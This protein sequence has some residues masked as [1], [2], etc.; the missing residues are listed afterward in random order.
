MPAATIFSMSVEVDRRRRLGLAQ[1]R[2][3]LAELVEREQHARCLD[4][5]RGLPIASSAVSPAM[6]RRAKLVG[7]GHAVRE[8]ICS[9]ILLRASAWKNDF[10]RASSMRQVLSL[11]QDDVGSR[12]WIVRA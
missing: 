10:E 5:P 7:F 3:A 2:D 6:K 4:G 12:C 11:R 1:R 8:A 9:R